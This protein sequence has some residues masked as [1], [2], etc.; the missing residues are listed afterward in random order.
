ML[1]SL[2][3]SSRSWRKFI[4]TL[5]LSEWFKLNI[6]ILDI[7]RL[8]TILSCFYWGTCQ[9]INSN[10]EKYS[11]RIKDRRRVCV[12][13]R[14]KLSQIFLSLEEEEKSKFVITQGTKRWLRKSLSCP[15]YSSN[16]PLPTSMEGPCSWSVFSWMSFLRIVFLYDE[17]ENSFENSGLKTDSPVLQPIKEMWKES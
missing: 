1:H 2:H 6:S 15:I 3:S 10:I 16:P 9:T 17:I 5:A 7:E 12:E 14:R 4:F 11:R 8:I 13:T